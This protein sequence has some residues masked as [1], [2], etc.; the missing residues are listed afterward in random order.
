MTGDF[1]RWL[2]NETAATLKHDLPRPADPFDRIP[3]ADDGEYA[4]TELQ[5]QQQR[6]RRTA[7]REEG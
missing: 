1:T 7:E 3:N 2:A 5:T 4:G 6:E